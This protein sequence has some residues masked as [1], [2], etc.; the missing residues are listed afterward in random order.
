VYLAVRPTPTIRQVSGGGPPLK[1]YD[2][3]DNLQ[4]LG[5]VRAVALLGDLSG[6][7]GAAALRRLV[8]AVGPGSRDVRCVSLL[9][10]AK[11]CGVEASAVL[12]EALS[13]RDGTVKDYAVIG[14]AGA[15]DGRAWDRVWGGSRSAFAGRA[16]SWASP[17]R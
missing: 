1:F 14:L 16:A 8:H 7:H 9:A 15:G 11:R 6:T 17:R 5:Q 4:G 10:L 2:E 13:D 12:T 3:R